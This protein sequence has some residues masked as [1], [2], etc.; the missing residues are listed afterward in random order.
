MS[1]HPAMLWK[2]LDDRAVEPTKANPGDAG[3]DL[4]VLDT[5]VL[6]GPGEMVL[7]DTGIAV[8]IPEGYVGLIFPRS[9]VGVKGRVGLANTVGVIDAGYRGPV[10][11]AL[12]AR[13]HGVTFFAGSRVAQLVLVPC[14]LTD[15]IQT[16]E[17]PDSERGEGGFG[18]SGT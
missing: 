5:V 12:E 7:A 3:W 13:D 16:E 10:K 6:D 11:L 8:A 17:L 14:V 18:S 1:S 15:A 9:S 4:S 2:K